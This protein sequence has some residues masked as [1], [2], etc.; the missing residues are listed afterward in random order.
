MIDIF[1]GQHINHLVQVLQSAKVDLKLTETLLKF[2][3]YDI[4]ILDDIGY[5]KKNAEQTTV[6]FEL[7]AH[8]YERKSIIVT[9]NHEFKDW[10]NIFDDSDMTVAAIDRLIHH[11]AIFNISSDQSYR[12]KEAMK[13][14]KN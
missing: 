6:L 8:R 11:A 3:K 10:D 7:I 4:L 12:K 1:I 2:D 13:N 14:Q 9:S 5:V